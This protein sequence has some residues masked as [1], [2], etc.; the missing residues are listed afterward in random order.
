MLWLRGAGG[1]SQSTQ[2]L[3]SL[4]SL[5][6]PFVMWPI[7]FW[8]LFIDFWPGLAI[9]TSILLILSLAINRGLSLRTNLHWILLG[10]AS[11][12][13]LYGFFYLGF[14]VTKGISAFSGGVISVYS[15][16]TNRALLPIAL[17]LIFPISPGEEAYW[18]GLIQK[19]LEGVRGQSQAWILQ[20]IPYTLIH[21]FTLNPPLLI[22]AFIGGLAW[23]YLYKLSGSITPSILSHIIFDLLIF[24]ILPF[25]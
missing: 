6:V 17:L 14:Q 23:G 25:G 4:A 8:Q 19:S 16:K 13:I 7:V 9:A 24:A 20:T 1:R 5:I 2:P 15:L 21:L 22:T 11:G 10:A 18:R 12:F 3:A